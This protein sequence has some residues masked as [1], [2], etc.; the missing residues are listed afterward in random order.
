[1]C[2]SHIKCLFIVFI[3]CP[4]VFCKNRP[5]VFANKGWYSNQAEVL[6]SQLTKN[7][8]LSQKVFALISPHAGFIYS[9]EV[10]KSAFSRVDPSRV[11]R[12]IILGP[13]HYKASTKAILSDFYQFDTPIGPINQDLQLVHQLLKHS[14]YFNLD[15]ATQTK[16]HSIELQLPLIKT[17]FP[18]ASIV[19]ILIPDQSIEVL[20]AYAKHIQNEITPS[21]L[22]LISTDMSHYPSLKLAK[23]IDKRS[24]EVL[25]S[26]DARSLL[27]YEHT[28]RKN[29]LASCAFC[30]IA[31]LVVSKLIYPPNQY[32]FSKVAYDT[33]FSK[34]GDLHRVVGYGGLIVMKKSQLNEKTKSDL[35]KISKSTLNKI[36]Q[37]GNAPVSSE[38]E[39][40]LNLKDL[41]AFVSLK[42]NH[43]VRGCI[44]VF[45]SEMNLAN[46]VSYL[47]VQASKDS[48][49]VSNPITKSELASLEIEISVLSPINAI[50]DYRDIVIGSD[51]I[52][53]E[54]DGQRAVFL[55]QVAIENNWG[56]K[57]F[58]QYLCKSKLSKQKDAYLLKRAKLYKFTATVFSRDY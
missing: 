17:Y 54:L 2:K 8:A 56:K 53:V 51:G 32:D 6:K 5:A 19:S 13:S 57:E 52:I 46:L 1:M 20:S 43:R 37:V 29:K 27:K 10:A 33:S 11:K 34:S 25:R 23:A 58:W 36:Y 7:R 39:M 16:E 18:E 38:M 30:G 21:D 41:G 28:I 12:V 4:M 15:N 40:D 48:R 22:V 35:L 3:L 49:F 14:K 24:F 44:G 50:S 47:T 26:M 42:N 9:L 55:P 31:P 45:E